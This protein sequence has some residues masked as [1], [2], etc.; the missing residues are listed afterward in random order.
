MYHNVFQ[1]YICS[2]LWLYL[3]LGLVKLWLTVLR[4]D[5][6][7]FHPDCVMSNMTG[8]VLWSHFG[9]GF[10]GV[11][12]LRFLSVFKSCVWLSAKSPLLTYERRTLDR[13]AGAGVRIYSHACLHYGIH[14]T[15]DGCLA[16]QYRFQRKYQ[17]NLNRKH[18]LYY[19]KRYVSYLIMD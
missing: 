11:M 14:G 9:R 17:C 4:D 3:R 12:R 13:L 18:T 16:H 8:A 6:A 19:V 5:I 1:I 10:K 7:C 15:M 2:K